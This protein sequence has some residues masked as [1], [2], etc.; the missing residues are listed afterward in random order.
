[1]SRAAEKEQLQAAIS[2]QKSRPA[3]DNAALD[4]IIAASPA[5]AAHHRN[6]LLRGNWLPQLTVFLDNRQMQGKPGF[7]VLTPLQLEG[8]G[9]LLVQR[10]WVQRNFTDRTQVPALPTPAQTVSV[11]GRLAPPPS[12][13]WEF[14]P[15]SAETGVSLIR[16]NLD[17]SQLAVQ[18]SA[19]K[20]P[21][22]LLPLSLLE[23][24]TANNASDGLQRDWLEVGAGVAKHYGYAAQWLALS[25]LI[26]SLYGW[27]HWW[28]PRR[29]ER[30]ALRSLDAA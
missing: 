20:I 9:V 23:L 7:F 15:G 6:A 24:P 18:L 10:G 16:Q 30:A 5:P 14:G 11:Q 12:K 2:A 3:L 27:F 1:M 22:P 4:Q 29:A 13:L 21:A 19:A 28:R 25:A 26:A 17:M 8:G